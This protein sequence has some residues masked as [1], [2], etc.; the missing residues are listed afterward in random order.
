M[1]RDPNELRELTPKESK[2]LKKLEGRIDRTIDSTYTPGSS[3]MVQ[4]RFSHRYAKKIKGVIEGHLTKKY[5]G[6]ETSFIY[7]SPHLYCDGI[8]ILNLR[9][10]SSETVTN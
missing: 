9:P 1:V 6:W 2:L 4:A 5:A 7:Q 8:C 10:K 3:E